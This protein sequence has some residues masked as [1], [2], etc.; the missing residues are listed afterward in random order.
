V[1]LKEFFKEIEPLLPFQDH[2][3]TVLELE[4]FLSTIDLYPEK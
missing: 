1:D 3:K 2:L 4:E